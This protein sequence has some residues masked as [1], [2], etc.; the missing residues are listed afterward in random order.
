MNEQFHGAV[1]ISD[2]KVLTVG[3]K[4]PGFSAQWTSREKQLIDFP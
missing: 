1:T 2:S 4:Q 3:V